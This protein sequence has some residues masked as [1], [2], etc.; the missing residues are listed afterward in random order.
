MERRLNVLTIIARSIVLA[1][2]IIAG[3]SVVHNVTAA[4]TMAVGDWPALLRSAALP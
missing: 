4:L 2:I 1:V 3:A